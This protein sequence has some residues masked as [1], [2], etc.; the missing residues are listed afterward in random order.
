MTCIRQWCK[1]STSIVCVS[2]YVYVCV[3]T[4]VFAYAHMCVCVCVFVCVGV[5][6]CVCVCVC[7]DLAVHPAQAADPFH[8]DLDRY[9]HM[10]R[11]DLEVCHQYTD[12]NYSLVTGVT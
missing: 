12:I 1:Y 2:T 9:R 7:E 3:R 11:D 10:Y 6:L 8:L 5:C 4:R